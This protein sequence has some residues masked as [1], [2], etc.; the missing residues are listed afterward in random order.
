MS[1]LSAEDREPIRTP[2]LHHLFLEYRAAFGLPSL[3]L[4]KSFLGK[5]PK[6][7]GHPVFLFPP[8]LGPDMVLYPLRNYLR[9][10][11][12]V[13]ETWGLGMNLGVPSI[14]ANFERAEY[15]FLDFFKSVQKQQATL[16]GWS[17]GGI[18]AREMAKRHP[19]KVRQVISLGSPFNGD[20]FALRAGKV[21]TKLAGPAQTLQFIQEIFDLLYHPPEDVPSTA[22]FSKSDGIVPWKNAIENKAETTD[23]IEVYASHVGLGINPSV[24]FAVADR[25]AQATDEWQPFH[26]E[27]RWRKLIYPSSG[28]YFG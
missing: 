17:L 26:R 7:D 11:G 3:T 19:E 10:L 22:V 1:D 16:I 8:F 12:Y 4:S 25:L 5:A 15:S 21:L 24:F 18:V 2:P 13:A 9:N 28:H 6:G 20:I 27:S 14:G 23:N